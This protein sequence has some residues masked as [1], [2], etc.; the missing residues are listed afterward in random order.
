MN[1]WGSTFN[2]AITRVAA[3]GAQATTTM[4]KTRTF[5]IERAQ[6]N[7]TNWHCQAGFPWPVLQQRQTFN[8]LADAHWH[9]KCALLV[10]AD[11][12]RTVKIAKYI[13]VPEPGGL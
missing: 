9:V 13:Q 3:K 5:V 4:S 12:A 11:M 6:L 1:T 8:V 7:K 2:C 10:E